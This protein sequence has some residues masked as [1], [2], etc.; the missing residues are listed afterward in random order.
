MSQIIMHHTIKH[1]IKTTDLFQ[2]LCIQSM[3]HYYHDHLLRWAGRF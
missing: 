2:Q 1:N 3:E